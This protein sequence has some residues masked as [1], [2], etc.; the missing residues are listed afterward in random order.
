MF[1]RGSNQS[2][3]EAQG[4]LHGIK[5]RLHGIKAQ[6][7]FTF[8]RAGKQNTTGCYLSCFPPQEVHNS[9]H[10]KSHLHKTEPFLKS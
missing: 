2:I 5:T 3:P 6:F 10:S 4:T 9:I 8:Q 1:S 7:V